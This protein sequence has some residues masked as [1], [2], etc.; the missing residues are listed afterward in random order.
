MQKL[1]QSLLPSW[2]GK[3]SRRHLSHFT[4]RDACK[5]QYAVMASELVDKAGYGA[6]CAMRSNRTF[7]PCTYDPCT[8]DVM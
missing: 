5:A 3:V 6:E 8:S 7:D 4:D 1:G 2:L